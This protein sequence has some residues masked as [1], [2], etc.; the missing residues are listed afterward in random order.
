MQQNLKP[1]L[2]T[3]QN[4]PQRN[5]IVV[6]SNTFQNGLH[7]LNLFSPREW[8]EI[9]K[10]KALS[11]QFYLINLAKGGFA[12]GIAENGLVTYY[13]TPYGIKPMET[14]IVRKQDHSASVTLPAVTRI[15]LGLEVEQELSLVEMADGIKFV[16][17]NLKFER[18][19]QMA[20]E[21]QREQADVF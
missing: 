13:R 5:Q 16:K 11:L 7:G 2:L 19:M 12:L 4:C 1:V 15:R 6:E 21:T 8:I 17:R 20:C 10:D 18:Q 3:C 9:I 14:I